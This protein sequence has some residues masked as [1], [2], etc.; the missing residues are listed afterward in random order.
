MFFAIIVGIIAGYFRGVVDMI[1]NLVLDI[2]WAYPAVLLGIAIGTVL[3]TGG[4]GPL[5]A[6]TTSSSPGSSA[7]STSRTSPNR[8]GRRC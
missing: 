6:P 1:S 3:A 2:I 4:I 7:S 8:S 5:H